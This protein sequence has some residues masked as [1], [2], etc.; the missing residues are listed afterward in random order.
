M[1]RACA[2]RRMAKPL[3]LVRRSPA[4]SSTAHE[5]AFIRSYA[6]LHAVARRL[7]G[8]DT[9]LADDLVQDAYVQFVVSRPDLAAIDRLDAYLAVLVRNIHIS[10]LR[11]RAHQ[12]D[13]HLPLEEYDSA[14]SAL[15]AAEPEQ[16]LRARRAGPPLRVRGRQQGPV[17]SGVGPG[18]AVLPRAVPVGHRSDR[19]DH[20]GSGPRMAASGAAGG[21]PRADQHSRTRIPWWSRP[22]AVARSRARRPGRPVCTIRLQDGGCSASSTAPGS[23]WR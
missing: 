19:P 13:L 4:A 1:W 3:T 23:A 11:R 16:R 18:A 14:E 22:G 12:R 21:T 10:R 2:A 17:A 6:G 8:G 9:D 5:D 15:R 20:T 7:A